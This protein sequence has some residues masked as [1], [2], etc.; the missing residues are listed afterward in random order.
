MKIAIVTDSNSGI[1]PQEADSLGIFVIPMPFTIDGQLYFENI[2]LS[3][4]EFFHLQQQGATI[5]TSQPSPDTILSL[6]EQVLESYDTVIHI[7]MSSGLSNSCSTAT[8]LSQDFAGKVVV[9]DLRRISATQRMAVLDALK[10]VE[11]GLSAAEIVQKLEENSMNSS[12]YITP[13]T[14][15]YLKKGGRITPAAAAI[16]T[17]LNIKPVLQI[18][19]GKLDSFSKVRGMRQAA[20]TMISAVRCDLQNRF[21]NKNMTVQVAYS[22]SPD[23]GKSWQNYVQGQFPQYDVYCGA[24]GLSIACHTGAGAIG[25]GCTCV[26]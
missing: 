12:I 16:G 13:G 17:V 15:Q 25:I 8:A 6:W 10:L 19:G 23:L 5:T 21:A 18:Q 7:P 3:A 24:L 9:A 4:E 11:L 22:G 26:L 2:N 20:D 1:S 14:L